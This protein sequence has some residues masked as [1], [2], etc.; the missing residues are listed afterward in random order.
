M[1]I[2]RS[3]CRLLALAM[4]LLGPVALPMPAFGQST[5]P[6]FSLPVACEIGRRCVVQNYFDHEAGPGAQDYACGSLSYD[7]HRGTDFRVADL[8]AMA[9][10]VSVLAAAAGTVRAVRDGMSDVDARDIDRATI[11]GREAGNAVVIS[12]DDGWESQY[13]HMRRG[14]V[15]VTP[16]DRVEAGQTLGLIGM[17]GLAEFPHLHFEVR[18]NDR[19]VDPFI[20][21]AEAEGC[22]VAPSALWTG[23]AAAALDY[24]PGGLLGLG[25]ASQVPDFPAIRRGD[26]HADRLPSD[27]AV[28]VFWFNLYGVR[29][30]DVVSARLI[31]PDGSVVA[32][33]QKTHDRQQAQWFGYV[34]RRRPGALWPA[35]PYRGE[36]S[37]RRSGDDD[38]QTLVEAVEE[39]ELR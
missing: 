7:G 12:H 10:G 5:S 25:F 37:L 14:S 15:A 23:T 24:M 31:A 26:L 32:E 38:P 27:A 4:V 22:A 21:L 13:S 16:G 17:S 18:L 3:N 11:E 8:A 29:D 28:L 6:V 35:G 33:Q 1:R 30:G 36:I 20:G 39:I 9:E 34:G 19:H 2:L